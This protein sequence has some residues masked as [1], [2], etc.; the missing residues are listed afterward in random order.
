MPP[1]KKSMKSETSECQ[2]ASSCFI[3]PFKKETKDSSC[4]SDSLIKNPCESKSQVNSCTAQEKAVTNLTPNTVEQ[5]Y[6]EDNQHVAYEPEETMSMSN[7]PLKNL[8]TEERGTQF[9]SIVITV[10]YF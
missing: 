10:S 4:N 5:H 6:E 7:I 2:D 8:D 9:V 1:F 3:P